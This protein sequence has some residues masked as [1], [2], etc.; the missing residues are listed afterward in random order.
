M[1]APESNCPSCWREWTFERVPEPVRLLACDA[2]QI[3]YGILDIPHLSRGPQTPK[4]SLVLLLS[5]RPTAGEESIRP[6]LVSSYLGMELDYGLPTATAQQLHAQPLFARQ[7]Q[8]SL[9]SQSRGV[10]IT[11]NLSTPLLHGALHTHLTRNETLAVVDAL[12]G[13]PSSLELHAHIE[14]RASAPGH[15]F[16]LDLSTMELWDKLNAVCTNGTLSEDAFH[17]AFEDLHLPAEAFP[18]FRRLCNCLL[19]PNPDCASLGRRP[20]PSSTRLTEEWHRDLLRHVDLACPLEAVLGNALTPPDRAACIRV[21]GPSGNLD[22]G[23]LLS[24]LERSN[25]RSARGSLGLGA[26]VVGNKIQTVAATLQPSIQPAHTAHLLSSQAIHVQQ[27]TVM[28]A[29]SHHV[30]PQAIFLTPAIFAESLPILGDPNTTLLADKNNPKLRWY[31]PAIT[32]V[33][34]MPNQAP[35]QSPFLFEFESIGSSTTGRPAIRAKLRFTL[36]LSQSPEAATALAANTNL[37]ARMIEPI[38]PAVSLSVPYIEETTGELRRA[39]YRGTVTRSGNRLHITIELLNDAARLTYGSLSTLNFQRETARL[40]VAYQFAGYELAFNRPEL[41]FGGKISHAVLL[42]KTRDDGESIPISIGGRE[43]IFRANAGH[44]SAEKLSLAGRI[45]TSNDALALPNKV[46]YAQRLTIRQQSLEVFFPCTE[47]GAFYREKRGAATVAIGCAEAFRLGQAPSRT[48]QEIVDLNQPSY[49]VFR[50]L[51]QPGRFLLLPLAYEITRYSPGVPAREYR[52]ALIV[53][54]SLDADHDERSRI[55]F[56]T[57]LGPAISPYEYENLRRRLLTEAQSPVL[58]LPNMLAQQTDFRWNLTS[59]PPV[60]AI[61]SATPEC[62]HT[63]LATDLSSALLLKTIIQNTGLTGEARFT[64]E[65]GSVVTSALSIH[66]GRISGPWPAG[67]LAMQRNGATLQLT[68][69]I[70]G[71]LAIKDVYLFNGQNEPTRLPVEKQLAP[72]AS[73]DVV[74]SDTFTTAQADIVPLADG[75]PTFEEVR[76]MIEEIQCN[77]VFVD[78]VNY[79]NYGLTRLDIETRLRDVPGVFRVPMDNRRGSV[80]FLLP[81]TTYLAARIAEYRVTKVFTSK[82]AEL[83]AWLTWDM[84]ARS[85]IVSLTWEGIPT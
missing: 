55:R 29:I 34:P 17:R 80:N 24:T 47:L 20:A 36:E 60:E 84:E 12:A 58:E 5:R 79:D 4:F 25:P 76:A 43:F 16:S 52:P 72:A 41:V 42:Q 21:V 1:V 66:L 9:H 40:E 50:N 63:A 30:L 71:S 57:M 45:T 35:D 69:R 8:V 83:T 38:E 39:S 3:R 44:L 26:M 15:S 51:Q 28:P 65:D 37:S 85:N 13:T 68:N 19:V 7:A 33:H 6:L 56:E 70:E 73:L 14:F 74:A 77:I 32:L 54:S 64:L 81:L 49:R 10:L 11:A 67:P 2:N 59:S 27:A 18:L 23:S 48:Y 53:Y 61:T 82:P 62:L 31:L 78:L 75:N 22:G 46:K